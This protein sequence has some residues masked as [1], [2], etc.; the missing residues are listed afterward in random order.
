MPKK[1]SH[2]YFWEILFYI[3]ILSIISSP[4]SSLFYLQI[5]PISMEKA[6]ATHSS[7]LAWK[8]PWTEEPGRLQS[9][10]LQK[11]GHDLVVNTLTQW[12]Q[13]T[14]NFRNA[15]LMTVQKRLERSILLLLLLL[16]S[17]FSR[18]RLCVTPQMEAHQA[19]LSLG[20]SRQEHWSGL[21][22]LSPMHESEK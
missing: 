16:L 8:I 6:M 18:V 20:F 17:H 3:Y 19:P 21:P 1:T 11:V 2:T 9:M 22:F 5:T 10:G 13:A 7:S 12:S 4:K 15:Q 14:N